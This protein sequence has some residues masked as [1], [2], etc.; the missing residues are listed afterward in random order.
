MPFDLDDVPPSQGDVNARLVC[1][2]SGLSHLAQHFLAYL[3]KTDPC[4]R[5]TTEE[6][7]L[8]PW[9]TS[10]SFP[11]H[12]SECSKPPYSD[13]CAVD[14]D[15]IDILLERWAV[16]LAKRAEDPPGSRW[17]DLCDDDE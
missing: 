3:M 14:S 17:A 15:D 12:I 2:S 7:L 4:E 16:S 9:F 1:P 13:G 8:H 10:R 11:G 6:A 5:P